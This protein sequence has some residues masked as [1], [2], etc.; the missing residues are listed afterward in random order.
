MLMIVN[1]LR[2]QAENFA[3]RKIGQAQSTGSTLNAGSQ[4]RFGFVCM[5]T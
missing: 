4:R 2:E 3:Q 5:T 1:G